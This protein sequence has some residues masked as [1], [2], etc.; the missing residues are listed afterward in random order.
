[1]LTFKYDNVDTNHSLSWSQW[2]FAWNHCIY[3]MLKYFEDTQ[4]LIICWWN[5]RRV[6]KLCLKIYFDSVEVVFSD[7]VCRSD[8]DSVWRCELWQFEIVVLIALS[9]SEC[10]S[11]W[12]FEVV[13]LIALSLS[14]FPAPCYHQ[15]P[16][17]PP[18]PP[19]LTWSTDDPPSAEIK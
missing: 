19:P 15:V 7:S 8:T 6:Y 1:M 2:V 14:D 11:D 10:I 16:L 9:L 4:L 17:P 5:V 18:P 13:L 12:I 3:M